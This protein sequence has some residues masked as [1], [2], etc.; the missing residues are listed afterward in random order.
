MK[1]YKE[2]KEDIG[3]SDM[4]ALVLMGPKFEEGLRTQ[5][6]NFGEDGCYVDWMKNS[7]PAQ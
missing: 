2:K 6:L 3:S 5:I 4:A 1:S 7:I